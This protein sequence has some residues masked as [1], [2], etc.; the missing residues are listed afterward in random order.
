MGREFE[1]KRRDF[2]KAVE[3]EERIER[4]ANNLERQ[5]RAAETEEKFRRAE[6]LKLDLERVIS[7]SREAR[8][9]VEDFRRV[10]QNDRGR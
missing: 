4:E 2:E 1:R 8:S 5:I 3:T 7:R 9:D 10:M 6:A